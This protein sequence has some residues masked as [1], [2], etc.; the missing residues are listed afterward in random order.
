MAVRSVV[1]AKQRNLVRVLPS[2]AWKG[3]SL[4]GEAWHELLAVMLPM[5]SPGA[6]KSVSSE[7]WTIQSP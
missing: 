1:A 6:L 2:R 7:N 3:R 5:G 4:P